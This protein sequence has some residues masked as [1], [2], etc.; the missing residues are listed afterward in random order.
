MRGR[1][2][3]SF[4]RK[5]YHKCGGAPIHHSSSCGQN[6]P[7]FLEI[8][9]SSLFALSRIRHRTDTMATLKRVLVVL[10]LALAL[11]V[12]G[13]AAEGAEMVVARPQLPPGMDPYAV[14]GVPRAATGP[15][16]RR[17]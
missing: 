9:A 8:R 5:F 7:T 3:S 1:A 4:I 12:R 6:P 16:I 17:A 10:A 15:E 11:F 14:I 13:S 2:D